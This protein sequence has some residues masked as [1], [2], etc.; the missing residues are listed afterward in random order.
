MNLSD[1]ARK[2][3]VI[4]DPRNYPIDI[5]IALLW[6]LG[7]IG[8]VFLPF[9]QDSMVRPVFGILF[10]LIVPGYLLT[11]ALF[12]ATD[13]IEWIERIALSFG[14]SIAVVPLIGL[15]LNYTP[16]GIRLIPIVIALSIFTCLMGLIAAYRRMSLP[17]ERQL[18]IPVQ[19]VLSA[20]RSTFFP[21]K[22][23]G[24]DRVLSVLLLC[25]ILMLIGT[26]VFVILFPQDGER[27]TEFY[28]LGE[29][30]KAADY[31][32][33]FWQG[34]RQEVTVGIGNHEH[35]NV[36]YVIEVLGLFQQF[37]KVTNT[38]KIKKSVPLGSFAV[39]TRHNETVE[40][41]FH[42]SV[43][44]TE[45]N[46]IQFLLFDDKHPQPPVDVPE[47]ER[48]EK[49]YRDLHF[50]VTVDEAKPFFRSN[51]RLIEDRIIGDVGSTDVGSS[52]DLSGEWDFRLL[53]DENLN[54]LLKILQVGNSISGS[55]RVNKD[56]SRKCEG[57]I[58]DTKINFYISID[59]DNRR[60]HLTGNYFVDSRGKR[61]IIGIMTRQ[62]SNKARQWVA[63]YLR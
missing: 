7:T 57:E 62:G 51:E 38:S 56:I 41:L 35:R 37:D 43:N 42:F 18:V 52:I 54:Y 60:Y 48:I 26:T 14:L 20:I 39:E 8:C 34:T 55:L 36:T 61:K 24:I 33:Q 53:K 63:D 47:N 46:R 17:K 31:P 45:I 19:E 25:A 58:D 6:T 44:D 49:S 22:T 5:R 2:L 59:S 40:N 13:D 50:W 27:F 10:L 9:L 23:T 1:I 29:K 30:G 28:I 15:G 3:S 21:E 4:R 16:F 32:V 12:P 11:A